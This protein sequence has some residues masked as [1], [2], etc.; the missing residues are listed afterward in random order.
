[1]A[2]TARH[3]IAST[4]TTDLIQAGDNAGNIKS[5]LLTNV[6]AST[7]VSVDLILHNNNQDFNIIKNTIIPAGT[8]LELDTRDIKID[9]ST[10]NDTLRIKCSN[11]NG[12]DVIINN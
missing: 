9:T 6:D 12:V 5:I 4:L 1:M 7:T 10:N 11:A 3:N 2:F 8:S